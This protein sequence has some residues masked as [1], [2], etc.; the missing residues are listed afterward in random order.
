MFGW[1]ADWI[2]P[3][4]S[5]YTPITTSSSPADQPRSDS[6][7]RKTSASTASEVPTAIADCSRLKKKFTRYC[8]SLSTPIRRNVPAS[9]AAAR[10]LPTTP[11]PPT[12]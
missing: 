10:T 2:T 4:I 1:I 5:T 3:P 7:C 12:R 11:N 9:R 6:V 8:S